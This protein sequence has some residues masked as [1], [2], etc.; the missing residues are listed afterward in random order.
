M[1]KFLPVDI[2][3]EFPD[4]RCWNL[5]QIY[6][7]QEEFSRPNSICGAKW[8]QLLDA[9]LMF[10][11]KIIYLANWIP[12]AGRFLVEIHDLDL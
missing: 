10:Q 1:I 7:L 2:R 5:K 12:L 6:K 8:A 3:L 4:I 9:Q 11:V